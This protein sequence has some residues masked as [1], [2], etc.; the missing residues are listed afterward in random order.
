MDHAEVQ[1]VFAGTVLNLEKA[2]GIASRD[3]RDTRFPDFIDFTIEKFA[4]H[5]RLN[6]IVDSRAAAAPGAL[7]QFDQL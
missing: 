7:R 4:G 2:P 5:F 3:S 1:A 6:D